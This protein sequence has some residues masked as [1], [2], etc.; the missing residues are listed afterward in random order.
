[1]SAIRH[2]R[3][4]SRSVQASPYARPMK[5]SPW[6]FSSFLNFLN[7]LR[8]RG[9]NDESDPEG[10]SEGLSLPSDMGNGRQAEGLQSAPSIQHDAAIQSK[11][12][13]SADTSAS[14]DRHSHSAP[15]KSP[16]RN[17]ST[18]P[19]HAALQP[20][21]SDDSP[22]K[23]LQIVTDFLA[24]RGG[25][26]MS[27]VEVEGLISLIQKS[28]PPEKNIPFRFSSSTSPTPGRGDSPLY[29]DTLGAYPTQDGN[30]QGPRKMLTK[31]PN[32]I[33]RWRGG[34]SARPAR[35]R[36]RYASPAF[37]PSRMTP[38]RLVLKESTST[39]EGP[40]TE[41]KRRRVEE[42]SSSSSL[43]PGKTLTAIN[44]QAAVAMPTSESSAIRGT[45]YASTPNLSSAA[46]RPPN[47]TSTRV[48]VNGVSTGP[49]ALRLR[50][51]MQKPTTP[52]VPS[53]LRQA[54]SESS[55]E[56]SSPPAQ[57]PAKPTK[58]ANFMAEL[59]K[60]VT[61]PKKPDVS[62]PY[63]TASPVRIG[64]SVTKSRPKK[65]RATGRPSQPTASATKLAADIEMKEK[66]T[67]VEKLTPQAIIEATLPKGSKR[68]RPPT[69]FEKQVVAE[70]V[71]VSL[72][73]SPTVPVDASKQHLVDHEETLKRSYENAP[74]AVEE[75]EEEGKARAAKKP[76]PYLNGRGVA[77]VERKMAST[78]VVGEDVRDV[79]MN[80]ATEIPT[81]TIQLST[82]TTPGSIAAAPP[83]S[84]TTSRTLYGLKPSS[85]PKEP[86][87]L[88][89]SYQPEVAEFETP[90]GSASTIETKSLEN[91]SEISPTPEPV[92]VKTQDPKTAALAISPNALPSFTFALTPTSPFTLSPEN[93]Q[94]REKAISL[95]KESLPTFIFTSL[96]SE[97]SKPTVSSA[98][99]N[100]FDWSAAGLKPPPAAGVSG[101]W[102]CS[103]CMLSNPATAVEKCTVCEAPR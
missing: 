80:G 61:P 83:K 86:S 50:P 25:K 41:N 24:E 87:K 102:T 21:D 23:N 59:I 12:S 36:N 75:V 90:L 51:V 14:Q 92:V 63:Q 65:P 10:F 84:P 79:E 15:A 22:A 13:H 62:N 98:P 18:T 47:G 56:A 57:T 32:G 70:P 91:K 28:A 34:G 39:G 54:W 94:A 52:A 96:S 9:A 81:R 74:N 16:P 53:P 37:G 43:A 99:A 72:V 73:E 71:T 19:T 64:P 103:T 82:A 68:S 48:K 11:P 42:T 67:G 100:T 1:M 20:E 8:F 85:I 38:E 76:K 69:S 40:R 6:S 101:S 88:R 55:S 46:S 66:D 77:P 5:K 60:E 2:D 89:F 33:Y 26:P 44:G 49:P 45:G 35:S 29:S 97:F 31:N 30:T 3:R 95:P 27:S 58:A 93:A 17:Q 7:P 4:A 78:D